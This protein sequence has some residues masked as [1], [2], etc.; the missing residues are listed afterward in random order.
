MNLIE[1]LFELDDRRFY[2][3]VGS[4][5]LLVVAA[6]LSF[7]LLPQ[8]KNY[9]LQ[10]KTRASLPAIPNADFDF[11]QLLNE[12]G[13]EI[14]KRAKLLHGDMANLPLREIEAFVIDRVQ[15]IAWNHDVVLEGV[16]PEGGDSID[17]FK[18]ILF[19]LE[20]SG[21]YEDLFAWL[22]ELKEELG[23]IVIKEYEMTRVT[24]TNVN[25]VLNVRLTI[26]SY[27]KE[28]S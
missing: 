17:S 15:G 6:V 14:E 20:I 27:R 16:K 21:Q 18:E 28:V 23:F 3:L 24:K 13:L 7:V 10:Q 26:A 9:Q 22:H 1:R 2:G 25:P 8:I 11:P 4:A 12:R 5:V 19:K